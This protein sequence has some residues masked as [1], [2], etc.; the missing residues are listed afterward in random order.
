MQI[1]QALKRNSDLEK[2]QERIDK[3]HFNFIQ[4]LSENFPSL[5]EKEK[6][7]C[8][9]LKLDLSSKEIATLN[10]ISEHAVMMARYRMRKKMNMNSE[11]NL[12]DFLQKL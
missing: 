7:L 5:T 10:D 12:V 6:R 11:E 3:V 8:V 4:K 2:L 9:M 1:S